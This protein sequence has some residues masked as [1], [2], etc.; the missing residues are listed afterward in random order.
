MVVVKHQR[1]MSDASFGSCSDYI[2]DVEGT[3]HLW[4]LVTKKHWG[5]RVEQKLN[6]L[7]ILDLGPLV[8]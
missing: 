5:E 4:D 1:W 7:F 3:A 2:S 6:C 8:R